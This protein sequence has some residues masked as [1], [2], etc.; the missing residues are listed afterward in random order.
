MQRLSWPRASTLTLSCADQIK[1][2]RV[3]KQEKMSKR[4]D[5]KKIDLRTS[6]PASNNNSKRTPLYQKQRL[7]SNMS[8]SLLSSRIN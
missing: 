8:E 2:K 3:K 1:R 5:W 6:R 7:P 4:K